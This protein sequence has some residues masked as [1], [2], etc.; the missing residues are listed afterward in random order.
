MK[1]LAISCSPRKNGNT[2]LLLEEVLKGARQEGADTELFS[3]AGKQI[4]SCDGCHACS[5][6]GECHI[7]DDMQELYDKIIAANGIIFGTPVYYYTMTAQAKTVID[8]TIALSKP[9]RTMVNKVGG[10]V[11]LGGSLGLADTLKDIYFYFV[12]KR[13]LP[14][15]FVAAYAAQKGEVVDR[16]QGMLAA[17]ELGQQVARLVDM[18]FE[19]PAEFM[20]RSIGYGTYLH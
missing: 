9:G 1:V 10:V 14:A 15:H 7:K 17:H 4:A 6:T 13:M 8:R 20:R 5:K 12:S 11:V 3:V 18:K 19:Y 2:E 16:E